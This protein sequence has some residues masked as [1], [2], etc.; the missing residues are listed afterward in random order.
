MA[1][2]GSGDKIKSPINLGLFRTVKWNE[3]SKRGYWSYVSNL[4]L[5]FKLGE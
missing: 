1:Q 2:K 3:S 5:I 4:H